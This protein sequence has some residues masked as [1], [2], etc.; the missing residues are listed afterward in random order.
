MAMEHLPPHAFL[1]V[2]E[3]AA[4]GV[5]G[6]GRGPYVVVAVVVVAEHG[7]YAVGRPQAAEDTRER[8]KLGGVAV[9]NVAREKYH[10]GV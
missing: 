6:L 8:F 10:I 4:V 9:Y 7:I 5:L 3:L 1:Q 2:D